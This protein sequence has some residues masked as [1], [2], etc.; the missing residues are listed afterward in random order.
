MRSTWR[1]YNEFDMLTTYLF[2]V[3]GES[4]LLFTVPEKENFTDRLKG[5]LVENTE[6]LN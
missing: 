5:R 6:L 1:R 3:Y 2:N 4:L